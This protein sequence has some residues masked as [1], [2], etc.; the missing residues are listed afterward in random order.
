LPAARTTA[1]AIAK[2]LRE[3]IVAGRFGSGDRLRQ[4]ELANRFGV[5]TTP[6]REA[7]GILQQQGL[8]RVHAQRG[9]TVLV[10][11]VRDMEEHYEIRLA[12]ECLAVEHA[13]RRFRPSDAPPLRAMLAQMRAC[14]DPDRYVE[15]NHDFHMAVYALSGRERLTDMIGQL[16]L[17]TQAYMRLNSE[18]VV[19]TGDAEHEHDDILAAC[20]ANDPERAR[21]ATTQHL[22]LTVSSVTAQLGQ[23]G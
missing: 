21:R 8:V 23:P 7:F 17:A 1:E 20:E 14:R 2:A 4:V 10:P 9:A 3:D 12:L 11:T 13:A 5:S 19:P 22:Q 6:V 15:L 18:Q 16:R